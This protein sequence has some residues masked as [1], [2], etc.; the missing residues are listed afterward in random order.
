MVFEAILF[1]GALIL[2]AKFLGEVF[3]RI[4]QPS[5]IGNVL[6]GII[7]GPAVLALVEPIEEIELFISIG[8]FFLFFLIGLEEID[9]PALFRILRRRLF[10]GSA[11]GFLVPFVVASLFSIYQEMNLVESFAIASVIGASSL[12]V[13]AKILTDMGKLKSSIGLEIF[14]VTAIVEFIAIIFAGIFIEIGQASNTVEAVDFAWIFAKILIFFGI[15]GG[16]AVFAFPKI[17]H[18][19][20]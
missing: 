4:K 5:I 19:I 14:T 10:L 7:I 2:S 13:T 6:A 16:F 8:I 17:M 3:V 18:F 12:G 15:A 20:D 1:L 9:L 11:V